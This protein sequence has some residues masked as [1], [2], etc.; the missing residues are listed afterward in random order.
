MTASWHSFASC[1]SQNVP[2]LT[3]FFAAGASAALA[4]LFSGGVATLAVAAQQTQAAPVSSAADAPSIPVEEIIRRFAQHESEFKIAREN[5]TYSQTVVV[6]DGEPG[7]SFTGKY[8][9]ASDSY[10]N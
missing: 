2:A 1:V 9:M 6:Q 8:E 4:A 7:G 5:Y 3:I 10:T